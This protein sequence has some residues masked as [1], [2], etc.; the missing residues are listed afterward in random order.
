MKFKRILSILLVLLVLVAG[1]TLVWSYSNARQA[2]PQALVYLQSGELVDVR[3]DDWITFTPNHVTPTTGF[4][5]YPGG[6]VVPEAYAPTLYQIAAQGFLVADVSMP[7]NLAVMG[8][9]KAAQVIAAH[10]EIEN[11]A[12]GGHSLGGAMAARF[13][14]RHPELLEGLV[15]WAAYPADSDPLT[16]SEIAVLSISGTLDGLATP[17]KIS[18]SFANLPPDTQFM[19]IEGGNHAQFGY[20]GEQKGDNPAT[21][22]RETQQEYVI[23]ATTAFLASLGH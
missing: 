17:N 6:N 15:L 19:M 5:F 22:S 23:T 2:E 11:W 14:A 1:G 12:I 13:A 8:A 21:I 10:P 18:N 9:D 4:I 20:Y 16:R 3:V 7:L